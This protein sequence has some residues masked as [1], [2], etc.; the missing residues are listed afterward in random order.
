MMEGEEQGILKTIASDPIWRNVHQAILVESDKTIPLPPIERVL[1]GRRLL[2]KSREALQRIFNLSYAYRLTNDEKYAHRAEKEMLAIAEFKDWNPS[3]YLDV[4]EMTMAMAIGYD[5]TYAKLSAPSREK[6][7]RAIVEK[8]LKTSQDKR[9]N[10]WL[11]R[12]N[13]WNQVCNAGITF[14]ALAV[15]E[16][17][18]DLAKQLIK[19]AVNSIKLPMED[20]APNGAY[21]E[22]YGYWNYGTTFNVLFLTALEKAFGTDYGLSNRPG[23]METAGYYENMIGTSR[24]PFNYSDAGGGHGKLSPA[25]FYFA[26]KS[27]DP[28]LLWVE[29][30]YLQKGDLSRSADNRVFPLLML[31]G[32]GVEFDKITPPSKKVWVG[33]GKSPV[34]LMRSSWTRPDAIFVGFKAGSPSA[35]HAHMDIGSFVMDADGV[36]WAIDLGSQNYHSLEKLGMDIWGKE[37][38]AQR[39]TIKRYN[40]FIHNTLTVNGQLQRVDGYAKIDDSGE[41]DALKHGISDITDLYKGQLAAARRGIAIVDDAFVVV[42]DEMKAT[43]N[44]ATVRWVMLAPE[45]VEIQDDNVAILNKDGKRLTLRVDHPAQ[46]KLQK[47]STAPTTDYDTTNEGTV[48]VGFEYTVPAGASETLQ[49]SLLPQNVVVDSKTFDKPLSDWGQK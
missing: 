12:S 8:G 15:Y 19:R 37:Q 42:R 31:L 24:Y 49:V 16:D 29:K 3:H 9:Y 34:T 7:S 39:W 27:N 6:I 4:G 41:S 2:G 30:A 48:L 32:A 35:P 33:Q 47:W 13:N 5:W 45:G 18:P 26:K 1:E 28:S 10:S 40:N 17:H 38:D 23:F 46:V 21:P 36:R 14:G 25:V 11:Q 44:S 20:Y 22:G 43:A